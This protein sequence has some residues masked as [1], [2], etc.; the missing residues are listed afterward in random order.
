MKKVQKLTIKN[1]RMGR[2][3]NMN[4][5][6]QG[7][8]ILAD[9]QNIILHRFILH[10]SF[11]YVIHTVFIFQVVYEPLDYSDKLYQEVYKGIIKIILNTF[12]TF[13]ISN[14]VFSFSAKFFCNV[15]LFDCFWRMVQ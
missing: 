7:I 6:L 13:I 5:K 1:R 8:P 10:S 4:L 9:L 11:F 14:S 15:L 2:M 3:G 12:Y